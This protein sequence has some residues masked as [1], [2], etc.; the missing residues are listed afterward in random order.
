[1][2]VILE[3]LQAQ[4]MAFLVRRLHTPIDIPPEAPNLPVEAP[5]EPPKP[6][7][8]PIPVDEPKT[9]PVAS[10]DSYTYPWDSPSHNWH[11]V[12]VIC[13]NAS[14]T[15]DEKNLICAC[16]YQ[17]SQFYN[18]MASGKPVINENKDAK[19]KVWSTDWGIVQVNDFYHCG[20]GKD[21]P[22][23]QAV[24]DHPAEAVRW[25]VWM[26]K[27]GRLGAWASY[28]TGAYKH[29]LQPNSPMWRLSTLPQKAPLAA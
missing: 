8:A 2:N 16:I 14:L 12:R 4:W 27:K 7:P 13:D 1:M 17:E 25:M 21:F 3:W 5:V 11:N 20:P 29:W 22:S 19:G 18:L 24:V 23:A 26:Y 28:S 10:P 9:P 6:V 15:L